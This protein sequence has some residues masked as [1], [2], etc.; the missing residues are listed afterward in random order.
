MI[1]ELLRKKD[2]GKEPGPSLDK[3]P[4]KVTYNAIHSFL[5]ALDCPRSLAISIVLSSITA[6]NTSDSSE[7]ENLVDIDPLWYRY[8]EDFREAYVAAQF[9]SKNRFI[10]SHNDRKALAFEKFERFE[11]Q[12]ADTN[13]R[14]TS[15]FTSAHKNATLVALHH[16]TF[17]K[18]CRILGKPISAEE[19]F[20]WGDWGPGVTQALK[21][22]VASKPIKY[23]S[24]TGIS[25]DLLEFLKP[26]F[27]KAYPL[28][29]DYA[30]LTETATIQN[31]SKVIT[32]PKSSKID[33]VISVEPG[34]NLFFSEV[35]R[36]IH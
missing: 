34:F 2:H 22:N 28:W 6:G 30:S 25:R 36:K 7:L 9:L 17:R 13:S 15:Y 24:E 35:S 16:G 3:L 14:L 19:F 21:S 11:D 20:E 4:L 32:V 31:L 33:R 27:P 23:R 18:I 5:E 10:P 12:C 1:T 29:A 26:L 8:A